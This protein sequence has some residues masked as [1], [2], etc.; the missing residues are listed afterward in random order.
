MINECT[1]TEVFIDMNIN[2]Y[3]ELAKTTSLVGVGVL[4]IYLLR[5]TVALGRQYVR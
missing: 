4:P 3:V 5:R 2:L 1:E